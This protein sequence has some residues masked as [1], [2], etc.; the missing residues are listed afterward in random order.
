M[1][2]AREITDELVAA[3]VRGETQALDNLMTTASPQVRLM[4]AARLSANAG[5]YAA[6]ED[7]SQVACM[8]IVE[9]LPALKLRTAAGFR[10]FASTIV[11]RRV[12]DRVRVEPPGPIAT[13]LLDAQKGC[14]EVAAGETLDG[15]QHGPMFGRHGDEMIAAPAMAFGD[16]TNGQIV[17]LGGAAGEHD[18]AGA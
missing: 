9:S 3:A 14:L 7:I 6:A 16:A 15:I 17:A 10:S 18:L 13:G 1:F 12:A 8:D 5:R 11:S 4:V 2:G